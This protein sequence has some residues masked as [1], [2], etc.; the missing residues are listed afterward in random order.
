MTSLFSRQ[1]EEKR[2]ALAERKAE[3]ANLA[4]ANALANAIL[5][6]E[7]AIWRAS[8]EECEYAR[9]AAEKLAKVAAEK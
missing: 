7:A 4:A 6:K 3:E 9:W 2:A 5:E 8:P 1:R